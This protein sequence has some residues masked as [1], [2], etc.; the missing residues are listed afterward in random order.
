M[1]FT[2]TIFAKM[3]I[4][5]AFA[6]L[7]SVMLRRASASLRH[8]V[9]LAAL[10]GAAVLPIVAAF[11]PQLPLMLLPAA[12]ELRNVS[13]NAMSDFSVFVIQGTEMSDAGLD[14]TLQP[15]LVRFVWWIGVVIVLG[16][17]V[18]ASVAARRVVRSATL[19]SGDE[20]NRL[21]RDL[22]SRLRLDAPVRVTMKDGSASPMTCGVLRYTILLPAAAADWSEDRRRMVLAHEMAHVKRKDGFIQAVMH[23]VC[24]VYWFHPLVWY[25][26]HRIRIER[27]R[28]CDD[29]VLRLG[30]EP[31]D[32]A[33]HLIQIV[34]SMRG[35]RSLSTAMAMAQP[36]Q[37]ET[38]LVSILDA[39]AGRRRPSPLSLLAL[40]AITFAIIGSLAALQ[41]TA[42]PPLPALL[43]IAAVAPA[44]E[45]ALPQQTRM[46]NN[47]SPNDAFI[48]P[49]VVDFSPP[50]YTNEAV[51][52]NIEGLVTLEVDVDEKGTVA[53]LR[54]VKGLGFGLDE[55]ARKALAG[56][57]FQPALRNGVPV[58]AVTLVDVEFR[59]PSW[60][61]TPLKEE[62]IRMTPDLVPPRITYR[63]E[64]KFPEEAKERG[65][66]EGKVVLDVTI[67]SDGTVTVKEVV[68]E[69]H[70]TNNS[71]EKTLAAEPVF[72]RSAIEALEQWRFT[73]GMRNGKVVAVSLN[74]EVNFS[75]R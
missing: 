7:L 12:E 65:I 44:L 23:A 34:R 18:L 16:R 70:S 72:Q 27:E 20:W 26:A 4:V 64:P 47:S 55:N 36:S 68:R 32:Y 25:A 52:A 40:C 61:R 28:A 45:P 10:A 69:E 33:D 50:E 17:F 19:L 56:W 49:K 67:H 75:L 9:W 43:K 30:V 11:A 58:R 14:R 48:P 51:R 29:H 37:L 15:A 35:G 13:R 46:E 62:A 54:V 59:I 31:A 74:V 71:P 63:V 41:V 2:L 73:P 60:Y 38:R 21:V 53:V 22:S 5:L 39:K 42:A 3:T 57:K 8:A 24:A 6:A 66:R 1:S